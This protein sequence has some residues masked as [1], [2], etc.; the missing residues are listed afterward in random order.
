MKIQKK[1][2]QMSTTHLQ[3][4]TLATAASNATA[5][6]AQTPFPRGTLGS[7]DQIRDLGGGQT[8]H[9]MANSKHPRMGEAST[10]SI[11]PCA[12]SSPL[13]SEED[14]GGGGR[15]AKK[16]KQKKK[17]KWGEPGSAWQHKGLERD[18]KPNKK[19]EQKEGKELLLLRNFKE[20][21][22][23][24]APKEVKRGRKPKVQALPLPHSE[25]KSAPSPPRQRGRKPR[26]QVF[27]GPVPAEKKKKGKRKSEAVVQE[28]GE[29]DN[30]AFLSALAIRGEESIDPL[31]NTKRRS[32]RQVKRRKYNEDLDFKV[33]DDDGETIAVLGTGRIPA[34][35]AATLTWQAE[36]TISF[37]IFGHVRIFI[38]I[39]MR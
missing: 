16:K 22:K 29:R 12:P 32:G 8:N 27:Q 9:C 30:V 6:N 19:R 25:C 34:L 14:D 18:M 15:W 23:V 39:A 5:Q 38:L 37:F 24:K 1:D 36:V 4:Y 35:N 20:P 28:A 7:K 31:D 17:D 26:E 11:S 33:V 21:R 13:N 3:K 10:S 2:K